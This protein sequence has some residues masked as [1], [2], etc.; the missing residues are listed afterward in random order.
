MELFRRLGGHFG[1]GYQPETGTEA[2]KQPPSGGSAGSKPLSPHNQ[3]RVDFLLGPSSRR[4]FIREAIMNMLRSGVVSTQ[5]VSRAAHLWDEF[6][7][8]TAP[9][10]M[11][12]PARED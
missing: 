11:P 10:T 8:E 4:V 6:E 2:P 9:Q 7:A 12:P 5:V 1:H 3:A